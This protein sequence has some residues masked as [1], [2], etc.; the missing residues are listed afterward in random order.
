MTDLALAILDALRD[1]Y[2]TAWNRYTTTQ[3]PRDFEA[4]AAAFAK[5]QEAYNLATRAAQAAQ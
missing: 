1:A 2:E 4:Q 3:A 5:F